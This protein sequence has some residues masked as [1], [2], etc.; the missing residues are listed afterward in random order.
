M[1][2]PTSNPDPYLPP[3]FDPTRAGVDQVDEG[4]NEDDDQAPDME[5][6]SF[7]CAYFLSH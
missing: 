2:L 7:S 5:A 1:T 4:D 6:R 3:D